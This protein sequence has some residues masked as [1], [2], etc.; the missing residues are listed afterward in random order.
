MPAADRTPWIGLNRQCAAVD[1]GNRDSSKY[2]DIVVPTRED[3]TV[4]NSTITIVSHQAWWFRLTRPLLHWLACH[5]YLDAER[6]V[7]AGVTFEV[8]R[9]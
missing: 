6:V 1:K 3:P 5:G 9:D 2:R 8:Q 7:R 4:Q